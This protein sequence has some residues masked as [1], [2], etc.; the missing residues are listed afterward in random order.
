MAFAGIAKSLVGSV[1][2]DAAKSMAE[3]AAKQG[4]KELGNMAA[5][6]T[7]DMFK[8]AV[9]NAVNSVLDATNF[10]GKIV[11]DPMGAYGA[12]ATAI[13][14]FFSPGEDNQK[15]FIAEANRPEI[16]GNSY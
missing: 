4:G 15:K 13:S 1:A 6:G 8:S 9:P 2:V 12:G 14:G 10:A 16:S 7:A 11:T 3:E 5:R